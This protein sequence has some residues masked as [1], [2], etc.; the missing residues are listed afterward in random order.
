M[1]DPVAGTEE[2]SE[3]RVTV[4]VDETWRHHCSGD[5]NDMELRD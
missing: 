2:R 3:I 5:A 1:K 4:G